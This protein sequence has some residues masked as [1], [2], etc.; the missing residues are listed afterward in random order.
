VIS[1]T[2]HS[3]TRI[4]SSVTT[5]LLI[6]G[7]LTVDDVQG[8]PE[9]GGPKAIDAGAAA[10]DKPKPVKQRIAD[11]RRQ[12]ADYRRR[13]HER[14]AA[15]VERKAAKLAARSAPRTAQARALDRAAKLA[16]VR[17]L[18]E[19][20]GD[21]LLQ[22]EVVQE[23]ALH[24]RRV[25]RLGRVKS[26]ASL[27]VNGKA[28]KQ[29]LERIDQLIGKETLRHQRTMAALTSKPSARH[30]PQSDGERGDAAKQD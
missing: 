22:P 2:H 24:G 29:L 7:L 21:D 10:T 15:A 26:L 9:T 5:L 4:L 1:E 20:Y 13:G 25:A 14:A 12:A 17:L 19:R 6:A 30:R 23:L 28:K 8:K 3:S 27:R 16:R 11:L 18:H